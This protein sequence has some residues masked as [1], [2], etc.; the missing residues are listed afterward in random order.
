MVEALVIFPHQLFQN[1]HEERA[2]HFFIVEESHFFTQYPFHKQKIAFHRASMRYYFDHL[3]HSNKTYI[4]AQSPNADIQ[5]LIPYLKTEGFETLTFFDPCDNWLEKKIHHSAQK[6]T[7][8]IKYLK[9]PGFI[10]SMED[11][12]NYKNSSK[13]YFQTDFYI[14]SKKKTSPIN[15]KWE[16]CWR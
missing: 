1:V 3:P 7:I 9:S 12:S 4:S 2:N 6:S 11:L 14:F 8:A 16:T 5:K 10:N 13:K 15:R